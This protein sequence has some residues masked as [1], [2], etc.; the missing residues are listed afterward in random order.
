MSSYSLLTSVGMTISK[1]RSLLA[2]IL[3]FVGLELVGLGNG[4]VSW[5]VRNL[6][7]IVKL[8]IVI[9]LSFIPAR[10]SG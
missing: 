10:L 1:S 7:L 9:I 2:S 3:S 8:V 4:Y 5:G 6:G